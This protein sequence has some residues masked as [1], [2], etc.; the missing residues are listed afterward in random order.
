MQ[1]LTLDR[2]IDCTIDVIYPPAIRTDE[3]EGQLDSFRA[4]CKLALSTRSDPSNALDVL[5]TV[6]G[7]RFVQALP[8]TFSDVAGSLEYMRV[9]DQ[10]WH[11][12]SETLLDI[13]R[14]VSD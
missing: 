6:T 5:K 1:P 13:K 14:T 9:V 12:I 10:V 11:I 3:I 7:D 4:E 8:K 2:A